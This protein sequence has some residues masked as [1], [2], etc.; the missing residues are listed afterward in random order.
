MVVEIMEDG[1]IMSRASCS[2]DFRE[3]V[4]RINSTEMC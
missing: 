4:G 1:K 3:S 2:I